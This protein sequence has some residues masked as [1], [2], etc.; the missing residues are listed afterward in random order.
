MRIARS[1]YDGVRIPYPPLPEDPMPSR[2]PLLIL[3]M[4]FGGTAFA[5]GTSSVGSMTIFSPTPSFDFGTRVVGSTTTLNLGLGAPG[6]NT[7]PVQ[8]T[9]ITLT[10]PSFSQTSNC[11]NPVAAGGSCP[12]TGRFTPVA[13]G[14]A[15]ATLSITCVTNIVPIIANLTFLCNGVPFDVTLNGQGLLAAA[16]PALDPAFVG[17][18]AMALLVWG[19]LFLRRRQTQR[20]S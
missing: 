16:V 18:L 2:L 12:L 6:S 19:T 3:M 17:A 13:P 9:A 20:R 10:N 14:P 8:V 11:P 4:L 7:A 15:S 5:G 1:G